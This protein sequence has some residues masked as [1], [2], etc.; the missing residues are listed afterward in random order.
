MGMG[1]R[2]ALDREVGRV[3]TIRC[4]E[5]DLSWSCWI[6]HPH[7]YRKLSELSTSIDELFDAHECRS[8]LCSSGVLN[9]RDED[10]Q[11][12]IHNIAGSAWLDRDD[13]V[14]EYR[15][16]PLFDCKDNPDAFHVP[17]VVGQ[18]ARIAARLVYEFPA[19]ELGCRPFVFLHEGRDGTGGH[20]HVLMIDNVR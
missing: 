12:V 4:P 8:C 7:V 19:L 15:V 9:V 6:D 13:L 14:R 20:F 10:S 1:M 16:M 5:L 18:M 17:A 3:L 11:Q 2:I